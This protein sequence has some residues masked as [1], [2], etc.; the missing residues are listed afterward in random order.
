MLNKIKETSI[1]LC[2]LGIITALGNAVGMGLYNPNAG[3]LFFVFMDGIYA[4]IVLGIISLLGFLI[5]QVPKLDKLPVI[6]WVS[7]V[8]AYVS[9]PYFFLGEELVKITDKVSLLAI[10]TPVLAYAGLALG[11]D[12]A[13]FKTISW[14]IIPVSL[15]VFSGTFIFAAL[16]AQV[17][18]RWEG[19]IP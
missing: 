19:V 8:A 13:Q 7:L 6:L 2:L 11:K 5:G 4:M 9:S 10:C 18:L 16:I 15:A 12:L 3:P 1:L 14:R 17:T